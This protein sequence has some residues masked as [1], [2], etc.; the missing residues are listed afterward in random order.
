MPT[1]F[2]VVIFFIG[3][4]VSFGGLGGFLFCFVFIAC[5]PVWVPTTSILNIYYGACEHEYNFKS[6]SYTKYAHCNVPSSSCLLLNFS[7]FPH[8]SHPAL[9]SNQSLYFHPNFF[10]HKC[11]CMCVCGVWMAWMFLLTQI[12]MFICWNPNTQNNSIRR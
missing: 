1:S 5:I 2:S 6:K 9:V 10:L 8:F 3:N 11:A 12:H 7:F 4:I